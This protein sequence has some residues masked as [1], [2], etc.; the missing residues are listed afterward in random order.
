LHQKI[1]GYVLRNS[2]TADDARQVQVDTLVQ[3]VKAAVRRADMAIEQDL[4]HYLL[5]IAKYI[6]LGKLRKDKT[7]RKTNEYNETLA[8]SSQ[9]VE[10]NMITAERY[11]QLSKVLSQ[12][13]EKCRSVLMLWGNGYTMTEIAK[14]M[15][16]KSEKMAKKKKYE[17]SKAMMR[18]LD[19]NA[20]V[21]ESLR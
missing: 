8:E 19:L 4:E 15:N 17:C 10:D 1:E 21:K 3:F 2:G 5:G 13:G 14:Q 16:Y 12:L 20:D 9:T 7:I 18:Y 6:W 11:S